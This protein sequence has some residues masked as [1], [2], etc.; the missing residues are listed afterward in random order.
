[1]LVDAFLLSDIFIDSITYWLISNNDIIIYLLFS[2]SQ[3]AIG[4][5]ASIT[6]SSITKNI[7]MSLFKR[8]QF[9]DAEGE[10]EKLQSHNQALIDKEQG[11]LNSTE[12]DVQ[13]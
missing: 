7:L 9:V 12:K 5:L 2:F 13:R 1:L 4:C 3:D 10:F 11:S 8:F 6:D